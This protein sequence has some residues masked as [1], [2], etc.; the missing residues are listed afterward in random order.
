[1]SPMEE[2]LITNILGKLYY[3]LGLV[4]PPILFLE[5]NNL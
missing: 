2:N 5:M 1:M 3:V 4:V